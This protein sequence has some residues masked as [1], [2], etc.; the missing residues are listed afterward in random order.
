MSSISIIDERINNITIA[1]N[2]VIQ[3]KLADR[4]MNVSNA[5]ALRDMLIKI[6]SDNELLKNN[7]IVCK[8]FLASKASLVSNASSTASA[9]TIDECLNNNTISVNAVIQ[10][11]LTDGTMNIYDAIIL[12]KMLVRFRADKVFLKNDIIFCES[13]LASNAS[14][15]L[16]ASSTVSTDVTSVNAANT[17]A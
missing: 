7:I 4:T 1:V 2:A 8:S 3:R 5:V 10:Q 14:L 16:N 6:R 15:V 11:K 12:R 9:N 17:N 13:F